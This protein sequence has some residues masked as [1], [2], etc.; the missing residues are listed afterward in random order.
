MNKRNCKELRLLYSNIQGFVRKKSSIQDIIQTTNCEVCLLAET[1]TKNV[2]LDGMKCITAKKSVGQNVAIILRGRL[3]GT[4]PMKLYEPNETLNMLGIRMQ[5]AKNNFQRFYT[6]HMKQL[7]TNDKEDVKNQFEEIRQQF[8]QAQI[9]KEGMLL[10][11][12]V[13]VHVGGAAVPG[14][15]DKQDWGG[16]ELIDLIEQEGLYLYTMSGK[17]IDRTKTP[18]PWS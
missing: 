6:T 14:C 7:S 9:C 16:V 17:P 3:A 11:G 15:T 8:R 18:P 10:V 13:N 12:D 1:M 5:V 2:K 4:V